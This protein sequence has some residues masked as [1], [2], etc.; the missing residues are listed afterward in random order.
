MICLPSLGVVA[1]PSCRLNEAWPGQPPRAPFLRLDSGV[2]VDVDTHA[3][4]A[5]DI[6]DIDAH[7]STHR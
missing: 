6:E 3:D 5:I 2:D 4:T 1:A 7:V